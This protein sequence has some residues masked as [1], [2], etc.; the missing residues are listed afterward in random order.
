MTFCPTINSIISSVLAAASLAACAA[1]A[2]ASPRQLARCQELY[3]LWWNYQQDPVF[4][5]TGE[6]VQAELALDD[7][8]HGRYEEGIRTLKE[9]LSHGGFQVGGL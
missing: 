1:T 3:G 2:P 8:Q 9:M 7:C 4:L 5:H 6:R